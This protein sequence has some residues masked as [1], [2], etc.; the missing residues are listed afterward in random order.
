MRLG[1]EERAYTALC[2]QARDFN[3]LDLDRSACDTHE[4]VFQYSMSLSQDVNPGAV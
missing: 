2:V 3:E 4:L 1:G